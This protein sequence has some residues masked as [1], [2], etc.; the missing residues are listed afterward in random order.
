[1]SRIYPHNRH[2]FL[3]PGKVI[4]NQK[5]HEGREY[6]HKD[7]SNADLELEKNYVGDGLIDS[8]ANVAKTG[9]DFIKNN[10]EIIGTVAGI[11]GAAGAIARARESSKQLEQLKKIG[12]IRKNFI[13]ENKNDNQNNTQNNQNNEN[14]QNNNTQSKA[15]QV[16][17]NYKPSLNYGRGMKY[18]GGVLKKF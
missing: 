1:M 3:N 11:A 17:S 2:I 9:V 12:E 5:K 7:S 15:A 13:N 10:K 14:N 4:V 16:I 6:F 18:N 8:I